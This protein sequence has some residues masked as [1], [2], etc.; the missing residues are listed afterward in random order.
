MDTSA[1]FVE[2]SESSLEI[3]L[4]RIMGTSTPIDM[5]KFWEEFVDAFIEI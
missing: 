4:Q 3:E 2:V 1:S 5:D